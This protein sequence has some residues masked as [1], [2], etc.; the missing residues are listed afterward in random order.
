MRLMS[1]S[2]HRAFKPLRP[3]P[4][5]LTLV[6]SVP[7][8]LLEPGDQHEPATI[9]ASVMLAF[10]LLLLLFVFAGL[11]GHDPWKADEAYIFG[12]V[13]HMLQTADWIVPTLAG[14]P[15]MEKP[16]LYYWVASAFASALS[17]WLPLHDGA[18][19][20]SGFF[21]L[22]T[23]WALW[24]AARAFW[25]RATGH[26]AI[27]VLLA[28]LGTLV[29]SHMMM[30]D[31]PLLSGFALSAFGFATVLV[32]PLSGGMLLGLGVGIGFLSKGL[33]A[34]GAIGITAVVLPLCFKE[35]RQA[36]Y[37]RGL[38]AAVAV[39]LPCFII[40]P[41]ALYLR[42]PALFVEWFWMNNL[43]RFLG[44]S[45]HLLGAKH[46]PWFWTQTIPWYTFPGLP[47]ALWALWCKRGTALREP[48]VQYCVVAFT[49]MMGILALSSSGRAVYG[50]PLLIPIALLAA[51]GA[52][53]LPRRI[54]R[55]W[56]SASMVLFSLLSV[57]IWLGWAIMIG[58]GSP[59][60]W[61]RL[62]RV[63]PADFVPQFSAFSTVMAACI[64][65]GGL[66]ALRVLRH[67]PGQG[68]VVWVVGLTVS[69]SLLMTLWMP[70]LDYAKS[71]RAV[72]A[73]MPLPA[74]VDCIASIGL[75]E[76]ERA[77]LRYVTGHNSVRREIMP[78]TTCSMLLVQREQKFGEPDVNLV[79]WEERWRG[80]RPGQTNERFW[81]YHSRRVRLE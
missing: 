17:G 20:A 22:V 11:T 50:W 48:P 5:A 30:P 23:C 80:A 42:S 28:C 64:T 78:V 71:Y 73:A 60:K 55:G 6:R 75:G 31:L 76:G 38:L 56:A 41:T 52:I 40:W 26:Y 13:H 7:P 57:L 8:P 1:I 9:G 4:P 49:V 63:L 53:T 18:R 29:Q 35:W 34:P 66:I 74:K 12:V 37:G 46:L 47:L 45:V 36:A 10:S 58:T 61:S 39:A 14:E 27:P 43:G 69:W 3:P 70:W 19:L 24:S 32:R 67:R 51:P 68:L 81:L 77:M 15:F 62:L 59:P 25:G 65:V 21:L 16:P 54:D 72:F 2:S 33:V 44:F 79:Q